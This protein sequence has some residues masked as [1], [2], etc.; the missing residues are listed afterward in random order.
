MNIRIFERGDDV[1]QVA[2]YNEAAADLPKFKPATLDEVRRRCRSADFDP[3]TRLVAV[4]GGRPVGYAGYHRNGRVN[5]PWCR[6]GFEAAAEP[7][8]A[9]VLEAMRA[10]GIRRAFAAYR[11]DWAPPRD[12]FLGH[13]F[14]QAREMVNFVMNLLDMPTPAM[15]PGTALS[16]LRPEDVRGALALAPET[17][18]TATPEDFERHLLHNT[19]FEPESVFVLRSKADEAP[20]AVAVLVSNA[21]YA[22]PHK[23]DSDMPCYRLGAFGS[24]GMQVKRIK[25]FFSFL[26]AANSSTNALGLDL[27]GEAAARLAET[28]I[29]W[30]AGQVPSDVPHLFRFYKQYFSR[31]GSFPVFER[32]LV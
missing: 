1:A 10:V 29:E 17:I 30:L 8:F 19:Y 20:V 27:L 21:D 4:E 31:Q 15:R 23:V 11:G 6:R 13:G 18:R 28:D 26:A 16:P 24:E 3:Q 22:D 14:R 2:I 9:G 5:F 7:L 25:G 32:D 12:F